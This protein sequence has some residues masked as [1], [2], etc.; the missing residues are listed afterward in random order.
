MQFMFY[1]PTLDI[2]INDTVY[3]GAGVERNARRQ[4]R[5]PIGQGLREGNKHIRPEPHV[6]VYAVQDAI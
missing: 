5:Q 6:R 1:G 2:E 4:Y 3:R